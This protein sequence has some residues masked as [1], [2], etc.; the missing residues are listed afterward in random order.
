LGFVVDALLSRMAATRGLVWVP[1]DGGLRL[2]GARGVRSVQHLDHLPADLTDV[3]GA[4]PLVVRT[5]ADP[6]LPLAAVAAVLTERAGE[7]VQH[8]LDD[9]AAALSMVGRAATGGSAEGV[10]EAISDQAAVLD[11]AGVIVRANRAWLDTPPSHRVAVE[12]SPLGTHYPAALAGQDSRHAQIAA[13]GIRS[14]LAG[15]LPGFQ[16]EYDIS[17][18]ERSYSMQ[19]DPLPDGGAVVRHVDISFRK[20]LQRQLAHRATHDT[21]TGLPNRMVMA[22]RLAQALVRA[23][24]THTCVAL[25]FCDVDRFK[26]INDTQG[27]AVGDQVLVAIARRLQNCVRQSDVVARFGGDEF[28]VMLEDIDDA[29][30][31]QR[32]ARDLQTAATHPI[33]VDGRPLSFGLSIGIALHEGTGTPDQS[34]IATLLADSDAAMYAAKLAGRGT[35]HV[36]ETA[37]RDTKQDPAQI[38]PALRTAALNDEIRMMVQPIVDLADGTTCS[39]ESLVRW[40]LPEVGRLSPADFL[41]TA[42][43]TG[44]IVEIGHSILRQT[45]E[46]ARRLPTR[47]SVSVNVSW[48]ELAEQ[49]YPDVVLAALHNAGIAPQRLSL[50]ILLPATADPSSLARLHRLRD[51]GVGVTL[52]AFGR[53]PVELT[54]L[55]Y[56][57][58]TTLKVDRGLTAYTTGPLGAGRIL[59]GVVG[60][61]TRLG[62]ACIAEG[63]ETSEQAQAA[64]D[65]GFT[66]GQGFYFGKPIDPTDVDLSAMRATDPSPRTG[67]RDSAAH[68][69]R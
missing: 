44:A 52:D 3:F 25:L 23:A 58:A 18:A 37:D 24:R 55:P 11:P 4:T 62:L 54:M 59:A 38:A 42:E 31:A 50:E 15:A 53:Q 20:H 8:D 43:E 63:I 34:E 40:D 26:Q 12:R 56:M 69:P 39:F 7:D 57:R 67:D 47:T 60:L 21:L 14:V 27:H 33:V 6:D 13:D 45:L 5:P 29:E 28:V 9:A 49:T 1:D 35:V 61:A 68:P 10:L 64:A 19:V 66:R 41:Q 36:F 16:S 65:L 32:R 30:V 46:F 22:D 48:R 2:V 17:A 51:A